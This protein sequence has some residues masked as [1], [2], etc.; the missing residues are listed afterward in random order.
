MRQKLKQARMKAGM[1]QR[2][3][4]IAIGVSEHMYKAIEAGKREGKGRIWDA[5]EALFKTPQRELRENDTGSNSNTG[6]EP[7]EAWKNP[8]IAAAEL[9]E[10][11]PS[12]MVSGALDLQDGRADTEE[13][14]RVLEL[15]KAVCGSALG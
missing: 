4:A 6:E 14:R 9:S 7:V 10:V 3:T 8:A 5:L 1:K 2:E 13:G 12:V 11:S 15:A